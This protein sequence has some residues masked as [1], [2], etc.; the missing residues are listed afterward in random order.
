VHC[1]YFAIIVQKWQCGE[2]L[3]ARAYDTHVE[4]LFDRMRQLHHL[5]T[6]AGVPYRLVGGVAV[7]LHVSERDPVRARLTG[8][9]DA[10]IRREHL[11]AVITA[12]RQVGSE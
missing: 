8:D 9:V 7:Y 6:A 11:S 5:L 3:T 4:Q 12:A 1:S 2:M 10:S